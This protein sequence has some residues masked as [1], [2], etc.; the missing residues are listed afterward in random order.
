MHRPDFGRTATVRKYKA[1]VTSV[2]LV[3]VGHR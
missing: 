3:S 1:A 2:P